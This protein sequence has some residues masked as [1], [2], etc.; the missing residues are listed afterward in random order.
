MAR[1]MIRKKMQ[2]KIKCFSYSGYAHRKAV[3]NVVNK[4]RA[5]KVRGK[6]MSIKFG[7]TKTKIGWTWEAIVCK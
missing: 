6:I 7:K 5:K 1:R 3:K 4:L 2:R